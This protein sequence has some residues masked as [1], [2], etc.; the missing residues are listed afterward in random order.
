MIKRGLILGG[1]LAVISAFSFSQTYAATESSA[2]FTVDVA[3]ATLELTVPANPAVINL[4]PT[5]TGTAFGTADLNIHVSTNNMTGYTLS[6]TPQSS[7]NN[8]PHSLIRTELIGSE[9]TYRRID[10]LGQTDPVST[11]YTEDSFVANKWGYRIL[12]NSNY[13]GIDENNPTVSSPNW[14][15]SE[16]TNG[17]NHN[18][19]VAAKVDSDTVSGSYGT[20][21]VFTA[22]TNAIPKVDIVHFDSNGADSG[23]MSGERAIAA[24]GGITTL[25]TSDYTKNGYRFI[26]WNTEPDGTG[27]SYVDEGEYASTASTENQDVTL[28]AMWSNFPEGMSTEGTTPSGNPGVTISRAYEIAYAAAG[29]YPWEETAEGSGVYTQIQDGVYHGRDTRWDL[30]GMTPEICYSVTAIEYGY[31][32]LDTRDYKLYDIARL[33]DGRCWFRDNLALDL[34]MANASSKINVNNSNMNTSAHNSLFSA[35]GG[36]TTNVESYTRASIYKELMNSTYSDDPVE[37]VRNVKYGIHYNY[38][39]ASAGTICNSYNSGSHVNATYDICP[40]GWRLPTGGTTGEFQSLINS[41]STIRDLRLA[42]HFAYGGNYNFYEGKRMGQ[43]MDGRYW[44]S[45]MSDSQ[46]YLMYDLFIYE[47]G[48]GVTDPGYRNDGFS[49][50]CIAKQSL[51]YNIVMIKV[52]TT[53]TCIYCH[54]LMDWLDEMEVEYEEI[55]AR[56]YPEITSVPVTDINGTR[57]EGFDRPA[58]KKALKNLQFSGIIDQIRYY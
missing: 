32:A 13:F 47:D 29:K 19:T 33:K 1:V 7:D 14:V 44:S 26:G 31:Q 35:G 9:E 15:T 22:T 3:N 56:D 46:T 6:M 45:T 38:C 36:P 55:D 24:S 50:R 42:S 51:C 25:P 34:T 53:P 5:M 12:A 27:I 57:I 23:D 21:L 11:G 58:I 10:T 28:Y 4:S 43:E 20:T 54:A 41:Y 48:A 39:A 18:L 37:A 40:S 8:N 49:I 2:V 30:Q 52:Y 16:P 17:I